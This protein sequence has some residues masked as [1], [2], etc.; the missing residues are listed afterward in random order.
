MKIDFKKIVALG[1]SVLMT[2]SG[3]GFAAAANYPAPF[4]SGGV[5]NVAIVYGTGDG[6]SALDLVEAS[7][8]QS[9]LQSFMTGTSGGT[10][11][12]VSGQGVI[13]QKSSDKFNLGN[14]MSDLKSTLD[15]E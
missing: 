2:I 8:I 12:T 4:V 9:N 6:V 11:S 1:T 3:I 14:K 13:I 7:N 5:A 15:Y 10:T